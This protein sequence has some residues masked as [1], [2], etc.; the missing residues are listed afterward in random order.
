MSETN[1]NPVE[2]GTEVEAYALGDKRWL[3][4]WN[5]SANQML[6]VSLRYDN[7]GISNFTIEPRGSH[8]IFVGDGQGNFC[9]QYGSPIGSGCPNGQRIL[10]VSG[11][12]P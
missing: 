9:Y 8:R 7:G 1:L 11:N 5:N 6:Y 10:A 2:K 3:C 4:L 12:C